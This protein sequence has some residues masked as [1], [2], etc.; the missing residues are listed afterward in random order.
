MAVFEGRDD[1]GVAARGPLSLGD[2]DSGIVEGV[3]GWLVPISTEQTMADVAVLLDL[4]VILV[5]GIR[6]GC[7]NQ[8]LLTRDAITASGVRL[9]GWVANC[10]PPPTESAEENISTLKSMINAPL[11]GVMPALSEVSARIVAE[12]LSLSL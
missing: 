11:W 9:A 10:L 7:L 1:Q 5:V 6:L 8:A 2:F 4:P 3:G 12:R